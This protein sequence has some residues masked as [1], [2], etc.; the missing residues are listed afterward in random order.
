MYPIQGEAKSSVL[1]GQQLRSEI[2]NA[3]G[4]E[5]N[6]LC[7]SS[8]KYRLVMR[9]TMAPPSFSNIHG[10]G[11]FVGRSPI[12]NSGR[13]EIKVGSASRISS[14]NSSRPLLVVTLKPR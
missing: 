8:V 9:V 5:V 12:R 4:R 7:C 1:H 11:F 3:T 13:L 14:Q 2:R 10:P 6:G